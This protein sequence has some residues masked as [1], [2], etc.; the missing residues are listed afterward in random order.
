MQEAAQVRLESNVRKECELACPRASNASYTLALH[1]S[2]YMSGAEMHSRTDGNS[3]Q[4]CSS[5]SFL[6]KPCDVCCQ[7]LGF[8]KRRSLPHL[9]TP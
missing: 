6:H 4:E 8:M 3:I 1:G 9:S 2:S 5:R 7:C